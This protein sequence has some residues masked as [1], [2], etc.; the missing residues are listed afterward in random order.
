MK[1]IRGENTL[2][3]EVILKLNDAKEWFKC[4]EFISWEQWIRFLKVINLHRKQF[5]KFNLL[6]YANSLK[7]KFQ[8]SFPDF[9]NENI[10][11]Y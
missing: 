6:L 10:D 4:L 7:N 8:E 2:E 9:T 11:V 5:F 1:F 3:M